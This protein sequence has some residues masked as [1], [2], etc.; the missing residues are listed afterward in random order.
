MAF[1]KNCG[2]QID[3]DAQFCGKCGAANN[4]PTVNYQQ[5]V[6][7]N[8]ESNVWGILA[9]VFSCLGGILGLIFSIVSLCVYKPGS[10]NR[11]LGW[12]GFGISM[13]WIVL[14][15]I[16]F[17]AVGIGAAAAGAGAGTR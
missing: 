7:A 15:I 12:I 2:N 14:T 9:I 6:G 10:P 17:I 16:L 1:C 4:V 8:G 5:N 11:K 3:D 13:A